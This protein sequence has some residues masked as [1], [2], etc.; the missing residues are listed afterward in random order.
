MKTFLAIWVY[1]E[2]KFV[3]IQKETQHSKISNSTVVN[4]VSNSLNGELLKNTSTFPLRKIFCFP[5]FDRETCF[6]FNYYLKVF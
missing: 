3:T 6:S 4:R 1:L 2:I 5:T